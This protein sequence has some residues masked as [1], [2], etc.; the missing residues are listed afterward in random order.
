M[1]ENAKDV[2]GRSEPDPAEHG[3]KS[4]FYSKSSK[5]Y[6]RKAIIVR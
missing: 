3:K 5:I 2:G 6:T 4:G 1:G